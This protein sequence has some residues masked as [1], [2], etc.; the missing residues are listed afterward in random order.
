V[1]TDGVARGMT[2]MDRGLKRWNNTH[3][4]TERP[5]VQVCPL[6]RVAVAASVPSCWLP[7]WWADAEVLVAVVCRWHWP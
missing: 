6:Q 5:L 3:G 2:V 4:W 1:L 7:C